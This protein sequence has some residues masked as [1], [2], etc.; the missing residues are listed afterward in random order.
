MGFFCFLGIS[1]SILKG[2]GAICVICLS[3]CAITAE[4]PPATKRGGYPDKRAEILQI[5]AVGP[6]GSPLIKTSKGLGFSQTPR[7]RRSY[8]L[9]CFKTTQLV[10]SKKIPAFAVS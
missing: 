9:C 3:I 6:S 1:M 2:E 10:C 5:S 8:E 4:S 7:R